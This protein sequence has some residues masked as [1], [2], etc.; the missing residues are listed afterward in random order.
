YA[1]DFVTETYQKLSDMAVGRWYPSVVT[2]SD[3]RQLITA[4]YDV[5]GAKTNVVEVFDPTTN[6]TSRLTPTR[7]RPLYPR[8]FQTV[9]PGEIFYAGPAGPGF[10]NPVTGAFR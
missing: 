8:T 5:T 4:G 9:R 7:S 1:F 2:M 3:G 6:V 10:W